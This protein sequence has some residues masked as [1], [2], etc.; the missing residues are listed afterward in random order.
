MITWPLV[1]FACVLG[2]TICGVGF[3]W[4]CWR[5]DEREHQERLAEMAAE[6][7]GHARQKEI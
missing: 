7:D 6:A 1:G 2:L 3:L 4:V 5:Q